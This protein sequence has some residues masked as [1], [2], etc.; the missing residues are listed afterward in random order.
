MVSEALG[1]G[2]RLFGSP[3]LMRWKWLQFALAPPALCSWPLTSS[4]TT[5]LVFLSCL[6]HPSIRTPH[7][8]PLVRP[9]APGSLRHSLQPQWPLLSHTVMPSNRNLR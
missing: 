2:R 6:P 1:S 7:P 4:P 9:A 5:G 8:H 3:G